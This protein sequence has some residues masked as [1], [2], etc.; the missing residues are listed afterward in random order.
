MKKKP[1]L[2]PLPKPTKNKTKAGSASVASATAPP[3]P[4]LSHIA[5]GLRHLAVPIGDLHFHPTNPRK[6]G[7]ANIAGI[8]ASLRQNGQYRP[9]IAST[10][11]GQ[12]VV[13]VGNGMLAAALAEG[14]THL[15]VEP[16]KLTEAKE[17]QIAIVD[18]ETAMT[19]EWDDANLK[20]LLADVDTGNDEDLDRMLSEL[21][22]DE[23]LVPPDDDQGGGSGAKGSADVAAKVTCPHCGK[24]FEAPD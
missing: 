6:H 3:A 18:N 14:Y 2:T 16:M 17:N 23:G 11:T 8:R 20:E 24:E 13:V 22:A 19:A 12:L 4:D 1:N 10:R 7:E 9:A 21:A 5:P 15:A